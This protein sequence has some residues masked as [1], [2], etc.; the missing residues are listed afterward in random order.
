[1]RNV[2]LK[3]K[4]KKKGAKLRTRN[5]CGQACTLHNGKS[6]ESDV[7]ETA[8]R[9]WLG[10]RYRVVA[11]RGEWP[12]LLF[13]FWFF[14]FF[15]PWPFFACSVSTSFVFY[16]FASPWDFWLLSSQLVAERESPLFQ[17]SPSIFG[18]QF[19]TEPQFPLKFFLIRTVFFRACFSY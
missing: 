10:V 4:K 9:S 13:F 15:G 6:G 18:S 12:T 3:K 7:M 8:G 2:L 5:K 19:P 1:M 16:S 14:S 17:S 11:S